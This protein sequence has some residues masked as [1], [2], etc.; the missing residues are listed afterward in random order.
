M[1]ERFPLVYIEPGI[2]THPKKTIISLSN[3]LWRENDWKGELVRNDL[4]ILHVGSGTEQCAPPTPKCASSSAPG[5][6]S[7][8]IRHMPHPLIHEELFMKKELTLNTR[9]YIIGIVFC[10][11]IVICQLLH[12]WF[13][14]WNFLP[15]I[16]PS[17]CVIWLMYK[18]LGFTTAE[19][20]AMSET[21]A[22]PQ[23]FETGLTSLLYSM[24]IS[25]R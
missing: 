1:S 25:Y 10:Q 14:V 19:L 24:D 13:L 15:I 20:Q 7:E 2:Q 11:T 3:Q 5:I 6:Y 18:F 21:L 23:D 4:D 9:R 8:L 12:L 17:F 16:L 22:Y